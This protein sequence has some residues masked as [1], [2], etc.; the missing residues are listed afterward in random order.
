MTLLLLL[1]DFA[2]AL[3]TAVEARTDRFHLHSLLVH[4]HFV[5]EFMIVEAL[6]A[7]E[8]K[9][10][11]GAKHL[12]SFGAVLSGLVTVGTAHSALVGTFVIRAT[13]AV[14]AKV[15]AVHERRHTGDHVK[16]IVLQIQIQ[17]T[18]RRRFVEYRSLVLIIFRPNT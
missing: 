6:R 18:G 17:N 7:L 15:A 9:V 8:P 1:L 11:V 10:A 2:R 3:L 13:A 5:V 16:V 12:L 4:I 14:V